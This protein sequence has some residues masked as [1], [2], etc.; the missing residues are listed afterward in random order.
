MN[1]SERRRIDVCDRETKTDSP[2][3]FI[4]PYRRVSGPVGISRARYFLRTRHLCR[5]PWNI[6]ASPPEYLVHSTTIE[7]DD[8]EVS[9]RTCLYVRDDAEVDSNQ[10]F[11]ALRHLVKR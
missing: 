6:R 9:V 5:Q 1:V 2:A 10:K 8:E 7:N 11:F 3:I 4:Q